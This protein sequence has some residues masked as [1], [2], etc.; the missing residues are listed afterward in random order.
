MIEKVVIKDNTNS[1][2][3]YIADLPQFENDKEY[4]FKEGVNI[5]VGENG[6]G[7]STLIKLIEAYLMVDL[8]ECS[9]GAYNSNIARLKRCLKEFTDGIEVY[10]DYKRNTFR[11]AHKYEKGPYDIL[12]NVSD[13]S[14]F[15]EQNQSST[16]E[17]VVV[18]LNSLFS[19][20]FSK[21]VKLLFNYEN[22]CGN[23]IP[24][25]IDY[26]KE[27]RI[28]GDEWTI[29]MDE[30]DRNL[31]LKNIENIKGIFTFHKPQ[32][33]VIAV[34]HNPLLIYSLHKHCNDINWIEMTDGYI[35]EVNKTIEK[36]V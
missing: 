4:H 25:Y 8:R 17:S 32:T 5:I 21:D 18:A 23:L 15:V 2:Y 13:F 35:D 27:H 12:K 19:Y 24:S 33:Q 22:E 3:G 29:L 34:L 6:C 28:K 1:P 31:S 10:A 26:I 30:P 14:E 20:M 16:G 11:L 7:K 9:R 36:L